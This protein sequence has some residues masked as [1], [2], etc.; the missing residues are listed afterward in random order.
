MFQSEILRKMVKLEEEKRRFAENNDELNNKYRVTLSQLEKN[1][2][3]L[4]VLRNEKLE[5]EKKLTVLNHDIKK[6]QRKL[7]QEAESRTLA[8]QASADLRAKFE[9]E[10]TQ[11]TALSNNIAVT[12]EKY[13]NLE[14]QL[15]IL[16][17]KLKSETEAVSREATA[18]AEL[19]HSCAANE[20]AIQE[21]KGRLEQERN[22]CQEVEQLKEQLKANVANL[23][24]Y[25][26]RSKELESK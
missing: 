10:R 22:K 9:S 6:M 19:K 24:H 17:E 18:N 11:R 12:N 4:H 20:S 1:S 2:E 5:V 3:S 15:H 25:L 7:D 8:E 21:L 26:A 16:T 14:K 23:N 13:S